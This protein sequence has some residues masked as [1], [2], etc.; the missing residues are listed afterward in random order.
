MEPSRYAHQNSDERLRILI[1][2]DDVSLRKV[3][4][5]ILEGGG[6]EVLSAGSGAEALA[7]CHRS[8]PAVDLL[9]T[10]YNM[11]E[12][13]GLELGRECTAIHS[14]LPVLHVSGAPPDDALRAELEK[15]RRAFLAKPFR[16]DELLRTCKQMLLTRAEPAQSAPQLSL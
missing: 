11:P 10:D 8:C 6:Y 12:M 13:N 7:I 3:L 4:Y 14:T 1:V 15:P 9:V 5:R 2:D 16:R